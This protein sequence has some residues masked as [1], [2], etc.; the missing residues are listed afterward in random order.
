MK[1]EPQYLEAPA[2]LAGATGANGIGGH[3]TNCSAKEVRPLL[4]ASSD[5]VLLHLRLPACR[6]VCCWHRAFTFMS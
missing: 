2:Q 1:G 5:P 4:L 6:A 3:R